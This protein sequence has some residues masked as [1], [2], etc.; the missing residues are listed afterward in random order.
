VVT[1]WDHA[2]YLTA[3]S[4]STRSPNV[5]AQPTSRGTAAGI[6][7]PAH[8]ISWR[9]PD[10]TLAVFP[11]DHFVDDEAAFMAHVAEVTAWVDRHPERIVLVGAR[12]RGPEVE[13]GWIEP[14]EPLG[15]VGAGSIRAIRSFVEKPSEE[16]AQS[17]LT[18]GCLWNTLVIVAK[19]AAL[20]Q[21]GQERLPELSTR[22]AH[23]RGF[24]GTDGEGWA[25]RQA[26]ALI[27]TINFSRAILD[28]CP[29]ALAVSE[30]PPLLWSDLGTPRR[31]FDILRDLGLRPPWLAEPP[32]HSAP[33]P[34]LGHG[35]WAVNES[36]C[37]GRWKTGEEGLR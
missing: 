29:S 5:L 9:A 12:P 21:V 8:W 18:R 35:P 1:V 25:V 27:P 15:T 31:V 11:S 3:E 17:C 24:A 16:G 30:L 32:G 19:V 34:P 23:L 26:Y 2:R 28:A 37:S 33:E 10:A 14:G 4:S 22:L 36:G 6:L 20:L 7:F 13:Y